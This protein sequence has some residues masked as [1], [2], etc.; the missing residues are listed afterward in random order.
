MRTS[1]FISILI[2]LTINIHAQ[3]YEDVMGTDK[4]IHKGNFTLSIGYGTPSIVRAFLRKE[5]KEDDLRITGYGPLCTKIDFMPFKNFSF[6]INAF[7][8][9]TDASWLDDGRDEN[10]MWTKVRYGV[11]VNEL[12]FNFKLNYH[13]LVRKRLDMYAGLGAGYGSIKAETYAETPYPAFFLR[14][15]FPDPL[16]FEATTG[17]RY[18]LHPNLGLFSELGVGRSWLLYEKYFLPEAVIQG[19]I[20]LKL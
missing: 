14:H 18:F 5:T 6:G 17:I 8:N 12:S 1:L 16:S 20:F 3:S 9:Y 10:M 19:G 7:Y 2:L 4:A 11:R 13:Y 15:S